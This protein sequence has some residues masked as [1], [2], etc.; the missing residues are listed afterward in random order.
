[1]LMIENKV[2]LL[3]VFCFFLAVVVWLFWAY[4]MWL[5][6]INMTTNES[7]K[8]S[9]VR[10]RILSAY[11]LWL[12]LHVAWNVDACQHIASR[13]EDFGCLV[14]VRERGRGALGRN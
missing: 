7:I 14:Q 1:M 9:R 4:H 10:N 2:A 13:R 3:S 5:T 12:N 11:L 8:R 6:A